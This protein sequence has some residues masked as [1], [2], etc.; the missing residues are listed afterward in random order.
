MS[1]SPEFQARDTSSQ[2]AAVIP[3][4]KRSI[5]RVRDAV[6]SSGKPHPNAGAAGARSGT[7]RT[8]TRRLAAVVC[9]R[10]HPSPSPRGHHDPPAHPHRHTGRLRLLR[11]L[12]PDFPWP[13]LLR[14]SG[15]FTNGRWRVPWVTARDRARIRLDTGALATHKA[16][17]KRLGDERGQVCTF[18][19]ICPDSRTHTKRAERLASQRAQD[20]CRGSQ[21]ASQSLAVSAAF[22]SISCADIPL[23]A[24]C[25][26]IS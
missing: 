13:P 7:G 8:V 22:C 26:W 20:S 19:R 15:R 18:A 25:C 12:G 4:G 1:H 23:R 11:A 21:A 2:Q 24:R 5:H 14:V 17:M 6:N 3:P 16:G 10:R 9:R